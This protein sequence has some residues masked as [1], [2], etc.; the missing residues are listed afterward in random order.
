MTPHGTT[1]NHG[2][3]AKDTRNVHRGTQAKPIV[4]SD[5]GDASTD[6]EDDDDGTRGF[7][8]GPD[9]ALA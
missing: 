1:R 2:H 8:F 7:P 5:E 3:I 9:D 4:L 6:D